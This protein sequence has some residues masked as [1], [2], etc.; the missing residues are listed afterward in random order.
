[1]PY[2]LALENPSY[3]QCDEDIK[4]FWNTY[5]KNAFLLHYVT[6]QVLYYYFFILSWTQDN[7]FRMRK[8]IKEFPYHCQLLEKPWEIIKITVLHSFQ[9]LCFM[10]SVLQ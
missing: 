9:I 2:A 8:A 5:E 10:F 4:I 1:M 7:S 3:T 6:H